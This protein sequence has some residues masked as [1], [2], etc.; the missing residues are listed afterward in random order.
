MY[1]QEMLAEVSLH[2]PAVLVVGLAIFFGTVGGR[3]FQK[4]RIP[5]VVGYIVIGLIIG[6]SFFKIIDH[7]TVERMRSFNLFALGIIG[8]LIGGELK[9]EVFRKYGKQFLVILLSEALVT[10]AVV[11]VLSLLVCRALVGFGL[12]EQSWSVTLALSLMLGAISSATAPAAT[13]DVIWEYKTSGM[14]TRTILAIVALDDGLALLLFGF[15]GSI[16]GVLTGQTDGGFLATLA[17]PLY[18]IFGAVVVGFATGVVLI[19]VLRFIEEEDKVLTFTLASVML[20]IGLSVALKV[21]AILAAMVLGATIAN[22]L[23]RRSKATF[24]LIEKFAPPIFVLFFVLVGARL[25][26]HSMPVWV[27]VLAATYVVG[28]CTGKITGAWFGAKVGKAVPAVR[29]YLGFCLFSQAGVA[30]GLSI[31]ASQRFPGELG[32]AIILIVTATTF[33]VQIAGPPFVKY[34]L[35]K[36]G[37]MGRNITEDDL[38]KTYKVQNVMDVECDVI[39]QDTRIKELLYAFSVSD[40]LFYPVVDAK[41][42]L[43][44]IITIDGIKKTFAH[45]QTADWLLAH[46]VMEPVRDKAQPD[47]PLTEAVHLMHRYQLDNLPV[48]D[49]DNGEL[50]GVLSSR[51]VKRKLGA[52][53]LRR[54]ESAE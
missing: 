33:L 28:R 50:Q 4:L 13:V 2:L 14:L 12:L 15:V 27:I 35:R 41:K 47:T 5:Q 18:E 42:R 24:S 9:L 19:L 38:M 7:E 48:V 3:V 37:E 46:D 21:D 49:A 51:S 39:P 6:Q 43:M 40:H 52:E 22:M 10:F 30:V 23:P 54:R 20:I 1:I 34:G 25:Q 29:K 11:T 31:L 36:A 53:V 17:E 45:Q 8:F 16:A 44:G 32:N 26:V